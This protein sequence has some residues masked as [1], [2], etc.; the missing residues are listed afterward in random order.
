VVA[1]E[2]FKNEDL[3][4]V[5]HLLKRRKDY[6]AKGR[7]REVEIATYRVG[8][9]CECCLLFPVDIDSEGSDIDDSVDGGSDDEKDREDEEDEEDPPATVVQIAS[10][11]VSWEDNW[12]FQS[13]KLKTVNSRGHQPVPVPMLVPNPSQDL[14]PLIGKSSFQN[15][16]QE[17]PTLCCRTF[18]W[19]G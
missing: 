8:N 6:S 18:F 3:G 9:V 10:P 2:N 1:F 17:V 13:R 4:R 11:L 7:I 12:L 15:V 14:R 19:G 5:Q 16:C